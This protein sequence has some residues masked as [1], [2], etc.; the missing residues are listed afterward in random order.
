MQIKSIRKGHGDK[1][2]LFKLG[3]F[4]IAR[5]S[6]ELKDYVFFHEKTAKIV[7]YRCFSLDNKLL[8]EIEAG[9]GLILTYVE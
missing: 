5:I 4:G 8:Y 9:D 1:S 3:Q 2:I 6:E 7:V